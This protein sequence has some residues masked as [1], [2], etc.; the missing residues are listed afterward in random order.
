MRYNK[1][2]ATYLVLFRVV[3]LHCCWIAC[4]VGWTRSPIRTLLLERELDRGTNYAFAVLRLTMKTAK[5][6]AAI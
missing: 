2:T 4:G 3:Y 5:Y 6:F 1:R